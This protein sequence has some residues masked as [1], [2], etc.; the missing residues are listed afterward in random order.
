MDVP[1]AFQAVSQDADRDGAMEKPAECLLIAIYITK[2]LLVEA[3]RGS[4]Q[5]WHWI[6]INELSASLGLS[7][8]KV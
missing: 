3:S 5:I 7:A 4:E 1:I 2:S 6:W 8:G